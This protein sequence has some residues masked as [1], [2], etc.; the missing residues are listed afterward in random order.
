MKL[1]II[2]A[3]GGSKRIPRKNIKHFAGKPMITWAINAAKNSQLFDHI[4]VSTDDIEIMQIAK[5]FGAETPF[6]RPSKLSDDH[7]PTVPVIAHA[8]TVC[9]QLGWNI[10]YVCCIYPCSPFIQKEDLV[11]AYQILVGK[12]A[13]FVYP[14]TEYA[15]P[16]QRAMKRSLEGKMEF[17]SPE[18]E[19]MRTQDFEQ[20]F[21]DAGQFYWGTYD[22]WIEQKRMH[23]DGLGMPIPHWRVIDIDTED[24]WNRAELIHKAL[25]S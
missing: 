20:S 3:R 9:T 24:D 13:D 2:P 1:C 23:T 17:L 18:N 7:T 5:E 16:T 19:L 6:T 14:V 8:A 25:L 22:A 15:H 11:S 4:V 10:K 21:H 12:K